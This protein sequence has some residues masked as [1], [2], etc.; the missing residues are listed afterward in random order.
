MQDQSAAPGASRR[1]THHHSWL[2]GLAARLS[3][4]SPAGVLTVMVAALGLMAAANSPAQFASPL[5]ASS[6]HLDV[7]RAPVRSAAA[8]LRA[9][10]GGFELTLADGHVLRSPE[11]VGAQLTTAH[12][13]P[14]RVDSA[15][16][17][18]V[19]GQLLWLHTLS[20]RDAIGQWHN[21]CTAH[22]D[23]SRWAM[24]I[25]GREQADGTLQPDNS[26]YFLTCSSGA[27]G[28]CLRFGYLPWRQDGLGTVAVDRFNACVRMVRGDY[29]GGGMGFTEDGQRIDIY[30]DAGIQ[31]PDNAADQAFEA[32]WS[33]SGAVCV[34]HVRVAKNTSLAALEERFPQLRG[35]TGAACTESSA[36]ALGALI[37]NR[38]APAGQ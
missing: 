27:Q 19:A 30:D 9:S 34:H 24:V 22:S 7:P 2:A 1:P 32:G 6:A 33:A 5:P 10:E 31:Q 13:V 36:R 28:K 18:E 14:L 23:G 25:G 4:A 16:A 29:G 21:L 37:F 15:Q 20:T 26:K 35:R 8:Q 12:G 3:T 38:S 17:I 11:L